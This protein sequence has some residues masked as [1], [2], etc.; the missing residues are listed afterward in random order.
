MPACSL[1]RSCRNDSF[2]EGVMIALEPFRSKPLTHVRP[3][4]LHYSGCLSVC[5]R[6]AI[7]SVPVNSGK[8]WVA[9]SFLK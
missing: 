1:Q 4:F 7:V 8:H 5:G 6:P 9:L 2:R 3:V